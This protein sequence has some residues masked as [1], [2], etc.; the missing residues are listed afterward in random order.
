MSLRRESPTVRIIVLS[1]G[2]GQRDFL[3]AATLLGAHRTMKK[4]V[5]IAGLLQAV[6]QELRCGSTCLPEGEVEE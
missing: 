6:Q 5:T 4:P 1:G 2:L 3:H